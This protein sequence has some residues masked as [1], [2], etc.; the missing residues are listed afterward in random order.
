MPTSRQ[1]PV[2][3]CSVPVV[4][5]VSALLLLSLPQA[6]V[7][8]SVGSGSSSPSSSAACCDAS[9][10]SCCSSS[11]P[12]LIALT[13][14]ILF[15]AVLLAWCG[16]RVCQHAVLTGHSSA[17]FASALSLLSKLKPASAPQIH[18][19][20]HPLDSPHVSPP[21]H[22][23]SLH[24][25]PFVGQYRIGSNSHVSPFTLTLSFHHDRYPRRISGSGTD[26]SQSFAVEDG[27][28]TLSE[29]GQEQRC[30]FVERFTDGSRYVFTGQCRDGLSQS[31]KGRWWKEGGEQAGVFAFEPDNAKWETWKREGRLPSEAAADDE[32]Q[33]QEGTAAA[34][35][36]AAAEWDR[37][38]AAAVS[39][40]AL[41][42]ETH[43]EE[44][45]LSDIGEAA[46]HPDWLQT[47]QPAGSADV[48]NSQ[49]VIEMSSLCRAGD[50][51]AA[52][53]PSA[54]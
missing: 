44:S 4:A 51:I 20:L 7:A 43:R 48:S 30:S 24:P 2:C 17:R 45:P 42:G 28:L 34:A 47:M 26:E 15:F 50:G 53:E 5:V 10:S 23:S 40:T 35:G 31:W 6:V 16:L 39:S 21:A 49:V 37:R 18:T 1:L 19:H 12:S 14:V 9:E 38:R 27:L 54:D 52:S 46:R 25:F 32:Q 3:C 22:P 11:A 36:S 41:H 13:F 29:D 8:Q 33:R